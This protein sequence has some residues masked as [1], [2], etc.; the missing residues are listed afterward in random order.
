MSPDAAI[1][2]SCLLLNR[3]A[4]RAAKFNIGLIF[5]YARAELAS[6]QK[7]NFMLP[8]IDCAHTTKLPMVDFWDSFSKFSIQ[9]LNEMYGQSG[10]PTP[11]YGHLSKKGNAFVAAKLQAAFF[12]RNK[13][14]VRSQVS[15]VR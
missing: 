4:E 1:A 13:V 6:G 10:M 5:L 9:E 7:P 3:L 8:V 12:T 11:T 14:Q 15:A 2:S